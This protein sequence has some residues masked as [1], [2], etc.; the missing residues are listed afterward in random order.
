MINKKDFK[1]LCPF[2]GWVLE[3]FP[4]IEEDFDAIT[5]YQ[6][7]C[8]VVGYLNVIRDNMLLLEESD[9]ELIDAFNNLKDYVDTYIISIPDF[10]NA[11]EEINVRLDNLGLAL[12]NTNTRI[13]T[14]NNKIDSEVIKLTDL[15][16]DNFNTLKN[17]VDY[18]DNLLNNKIENLEIGAINVYDP[19]TGLLSPLQIVINNIA[20]ATNRDGLTA[21]E[22]DSL[23]L[24]A[25]AFDNYEITA[26]DFDSAGKVILV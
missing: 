24:T 22:F 2:K 11:I 19:T 21:T 17:Y 14:L 1:T 10:R 6:L 20:Q 18:Q 5:N 4:Y 16:N 26:Y 23:D 8:K 13:D 7:F 25:T 9:N 15:I 12:Q 3:S